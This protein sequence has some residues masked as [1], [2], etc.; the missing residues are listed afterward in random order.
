MGHHQAPPPAQD[1]AQRVQALALAALARRNRR[2]ALQSLD[3]LRDVPDS[4]I[5]RLAELCIFRAFPIGST[6][7]RERKFGEF[8]YII[9]HGTVR[10]TLHDREGREVLLGVLDRGDCIGEGPLFGDYF[11]RVTVIVERACNI[12]QIPLSDVR[13]LITNAPRLSE[14]LHATYRQRLSHT[15]LGRVPLFNKLSH[16]DRAS[17][18]SLL[19]PA[20]YERG[21]AVVEQGTSGKAL[22]LI[23]AGQAVV[24]RDGLPIAYLDEGGFF[25]EMSLLEDK[26]HNAT[27]RALTPLTVLTLP[28]QQFK[29]LLERNPNLASSLK[30]VVEERRTT[31]AA[32]KNDRD[33]TRQLT[34]AVQNGLLRGSSVLARVPALCPIGCRICE[35]ACA[36]RFGQTR[37]HLNGTALGELDVVDAC[38][39]CRVGAECIEACPEDALSWD[40]RGVL[41]VN[42][43]CTACG[44]CVSACP[45][46]AVELPPEHL[47][48]N[49]PLWQLWGAMQQRMRQHTIPLEPVRS[50]RRASKCDLC[51]GHST[52]ACLSACP[53]G[54]L[55]LI[56]VEEL[57]PL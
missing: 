51:H 10:V 45:Y 48:R 36:E 26:P 20:D 32:M 30:E 13:E 17:M 27:V 18:L 4:D 34:A 2:E 53:T 55:R 40:D 5:D 43:S 33:R 44:D 9:L 15:T 11:R 50:T 8:L 46:G 31:S 52:M 22:Y 21:A 39:Q 24:E 23:E 14:A 28:A 7:L 25:G 35:T 49:G 1:E 16:I 42:N 29:S 38:R 54:S 12:L 3:C 6:I 47:E 57:F 37:L 41:V 56:S 19:Q